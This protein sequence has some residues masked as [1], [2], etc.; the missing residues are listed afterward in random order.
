MI[1]IFVPLLLAGAAALTQPPVTHHPVRAFT[2]CA[3]VTE[4]DV[5]QVLGRRIKA[6][7]EQTSGNQSTCDYASSAGQVTITLQKLD[8]P[9]DPAA[10]MADIVSAL[11]GAVARPVD[12]KDVQAFF[13]DIGGTGTQLHVLRDKRQHI[14]ISILGFG[15]PS[16][17]SAAATALARTA[18][19]R[20]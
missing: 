3:A 12:S 18:L 10:A 2:A 16:Q 4:W 8:E 17:V 11:P 6:A 5:A 9:V 14:M 15:T 20:L 7:G 13:I 19:K 1:S